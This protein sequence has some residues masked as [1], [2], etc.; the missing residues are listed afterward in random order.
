MRIR[1]LL[2]ASMALSALPMMARDVHGINGFYN[3]TAQQINA[4]GNMFSWFVEGS[5]YEGF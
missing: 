5:K 4:T 3:Y 2:L 1:H